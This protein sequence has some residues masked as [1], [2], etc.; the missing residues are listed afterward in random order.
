MGGA[1]A[2][3]GYS[4]FSIDCGA[5][6]ISTLRDDNV[7]FPYYGCDRA[8]MFSA[9][10]RGGFDFHFG[11]L[12][13]WDEDDDWN[14]DLDASPNWIVF[15]DAARGWAHDESKLRGA[16]DTDWLYD[17]GAGLLLG[18]FGIY[19]A[20]PLTGEDRDMRFFIRLGARF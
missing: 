5:R 17:V 12:N 8:A 16:A 7:F 18:D 3:P 10:Y 19:A 9:E 1:G 13:S 6:S 4:T 20:V 2:M 15:F 11:G 14:W